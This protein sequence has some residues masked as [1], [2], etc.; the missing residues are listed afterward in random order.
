MIRRIW[1]ITLTVKDLKKAVEFYEDVLVLEKY[2][3]KDFI[4]H[5]ILPEYLF[6]HTIQ[7]DNM[8]AKVRWIDDMKFSGECDGKSIEIGGENL[9][10]MQLILMSVAGCT[11][12]DVVDILKKFREPVE[13]FGI[14]I[15]GERREEYPRYFT[16][17]KLNYKFKG[18]L[19]RDKV[20]RAIELSQGKYCSA[21]AQMKIG[22]V[23]VEW[24][25]EIKE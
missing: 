9:T 8:K 23:K 4:Q 15:E 5:R 7:K 16:K 14:E 1:D 24:E 3:F 6:K 13:G 17:I 2:Q 22:G 18:K 19:N 20:I 21:L 25:Y 12:Y 10:P 11:S